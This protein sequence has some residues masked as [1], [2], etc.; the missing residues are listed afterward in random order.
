MW[1]SVSGE[2]QVAMLFCS[3]GKCKTSFDKLKAIPSYL[4]NCPLVISVTVSPQK[5]WTSV[6]CWQTANAEKNTIFTA[7]RNW[8]IQHFPIGVDLSP[9]LMPESEHSAGF[10]C[11]I[12]P[13]SLNVRFSMVV[14]TSND[15][16]NNQKNPVFLT[17]PKIG[18]E[19]KSTS[20]GSDSKWILIK[21]IL[22]L[23]ILRIMQP[24]EERILSINHVDFVFFPSKCSNLFNYVRIL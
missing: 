15:L 3:C 6:T 8:N 5:V 9:P 14:S 21:Q 23:F 7:A 12:D 19:S 16:S 4:E 22:L 13:F 20:V 11:C 1:G 10:H 24:F 18:M 2:V 17:K